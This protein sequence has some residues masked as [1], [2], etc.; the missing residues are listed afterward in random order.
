MFRAAQKK[1]ADGEKR[2]GDEARQELA[3]E[4]KPPSI[5]GLNQHAEVQL[6]LK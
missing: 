1:K 5:L 4:Q 2:K 6:V 3:E